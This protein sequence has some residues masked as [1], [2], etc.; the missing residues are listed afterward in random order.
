MGHHDTERHQPRQSIQKVAQRDAVSVAEMTGEA[1]GAQT[2]RS[3]SPRPY[4]FGG[5]PWKV[6]RLEGPPARV[7]RPPRRRRADL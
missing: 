6:N 1:D 3:A 5:L 2:S 7:H 4:T